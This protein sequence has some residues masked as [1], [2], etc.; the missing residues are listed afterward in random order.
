MTTSKACFHKSA[1]LAQK[2]RNLSG[3][4]TEQWASNGRHKCDAAA[5]RRDRRYPLKLLNLDFELVLRP[6][7]E[8][9]ARLYAPGANRSPCLPGLAISYE[10]PTIRSAVRENGVLATR[11][12]E[13]KTAG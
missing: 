5:P 6:P 9:N 2:D 10:L 4:A 1:G 13:E 7:I 3:N 12:S 8:S 11:E